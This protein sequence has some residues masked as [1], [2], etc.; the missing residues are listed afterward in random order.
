MQLNSEKI[1]NMKHN[2]PPWSGNCTSFCC[3][4]VVSS[5]QSLIDGDAFP[6]SVEFSR[7]LDAAV[8]TPLC[9]EH[10][11]RQSTLPTT[12]CAHK[13]FH[14]WAF[15]CPPLLIITLKVTS[16]SE[17]MIFPNSCSSN[18]AHWLACIVL[19]RQVMKWKP[20]I[21]FTLHGTWL[22]TSAIV[23]AY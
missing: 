14:P 21:L 20:V 13:L 2:Q 23:I 7:H 12:G 22:G 10:E 18:A 1:I 9:C 11:S 6:V 8:V 3:F 17:Q 5:F 4:L 16:S 19:S 15:A